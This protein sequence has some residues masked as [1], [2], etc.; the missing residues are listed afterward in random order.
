MVLDDEVF[1][2]T[3]NSRQW[4]VDD[5]PAGE[6]SLLFDLGGISAGV[7]RFPPGGEEPIEW[8]L[9]AREVIVVLEGA[10]QIEIA[11]GPTLRLEVGDLASLPTGA[12]T[13]WHLTLPYREAWVL[14]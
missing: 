1:V 11:D 13:R 14:V 2:S 4:V 10:A 3:A 5:D 9:P 7:Q 12:R 6:T 8:T